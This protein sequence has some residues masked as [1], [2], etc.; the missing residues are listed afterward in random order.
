MVHAAALVIALSS[1]KYVKCTI[2][3][4]DL[5]F[6]ATVAPAYNAAVQSGPLIVQVRVKAPHLEA[7]WSLVSDMTLVS[8]T[9]ESLKA[10]TPQVQADDGGVASFFFAGLSGGRTYHVELHWHEPGL[11]G[12]PPAKWTSLLGQF[13]TL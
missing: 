9:G 2:P 1:T 5:P 6:F 4:S 12:C 10:G 13:T 11:P 8:S 7:P 3:S